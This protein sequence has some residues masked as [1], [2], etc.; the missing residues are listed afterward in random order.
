[1]KYEF[2]LVDVFTDRPFGG[3]QLAVLP[4]AQ[5]LTAAQM[6]AIAR[7][8]NFAESTFVLPPTT[9]GS[10]AHLRIFSPGEEMPFAGH[11]T[12]GT[13]AVLARRGVGVTRAGTTEIVFDETVGPVA[14]TVDTRDGQVFSELRLQPRLDQPAGAPPAAALAAALSLK[15]EEILDTWFAGVGLPFVFCHLASES[16]VDAAVLNRQA[17]QAA[18]G[19]AW[20]RNLLFFAGEL[21]DGATVHARMFAPVIGV[22]EDPATGSACAALAAWLAS[23]DPRPDLR[24]S[25]TVHQG[26]KLGRPSV[27]LGGALKAAGTV[28]SVSVGGGVAFVGGGFIEVPEA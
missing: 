21:A 4:D 24:L 3:N 25:I 13:G 5:G 8:F 20:A 15:P 18:L 6:Q 10:T 2:E 1:M 17:F 23:R 22:E 7:E 26:V 14:V 19:E 12:V 11:P 9:P 27:L 28:R 16:A